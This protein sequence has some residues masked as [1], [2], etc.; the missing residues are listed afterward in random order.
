MVLPEEFFEDE[1]F[2]GVVERKIREFGIN[3]E[4][5]IVGSGIASLNATTGLEEFGFFKKASSGLN[6][7]MK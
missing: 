7:L 2:E 6:F 1:E 3:P 4:R 5:A